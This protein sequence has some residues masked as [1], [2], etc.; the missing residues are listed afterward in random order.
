MIRRQLL[1][2]ILRTLASSF[3]VWLCVTWFGTVAAVVRDPCPAG[4]QCFSAGMPNPLLG[5]DAWL[6]YLVAGL[7]FSI[8]N[9][10][11]KPLVKVMV[12]PLAILTMGLS[13]IFINIGMIFLT[14]HALPGVEMSFW[15][16]LAAS[17]VLSVINSLVNL[18]M[19]SYNK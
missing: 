18:V 2:F 7:V 12:L 13:T 14:L 16:A 17:F 10:I 6:Y 8:C 1:V 9:S 15:G 5:S 3:G 19:P 11:V 4:A